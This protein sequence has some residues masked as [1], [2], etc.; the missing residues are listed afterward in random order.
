MWTSPPS[1]EYWPPPPTD[2][3]RLKIIGFMVLGGL[4]LLAI[5]L[6]V[7]LM[8][9]TAVHAQPVDACR[10]AIDGEANLRDR[11]R[12]LPG[13]ATRAPKVLQNIEHGETQRIVKGIAHNLKGGKVTTYPSSAERA[14]WE[15]H[16]CR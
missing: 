1:S 4:F 13:L 2:K 11:N 5:P 3:R 9:S 6:T 7:L 12:I 15:T 14:V 16:D 10:T 8:A